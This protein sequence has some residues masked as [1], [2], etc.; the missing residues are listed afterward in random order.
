MYSPSFEALRQKVKEDMDKRPLSDIER[1][2]WLLNLSAAFDDDQ[3][4]EL[5]QTLMSLRDEKKRFERIMNKGG[6]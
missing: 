3:F 1:L 2:T 4:T 6:F 5:L